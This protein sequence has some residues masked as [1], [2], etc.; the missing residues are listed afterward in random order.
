MSTSLS[1]LLLA[2]R[3]QWHFPVNSDLTVD[4]KRPQAAIAK[5]KL[6]KVDKEL[7]SANTLGPEPYRELSSGRNDILLDVRIGRD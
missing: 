2:R 7:A 1:V 5:C 3:T 6:Q 4:F